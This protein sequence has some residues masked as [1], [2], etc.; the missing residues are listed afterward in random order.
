LN[1]NSNML[2]W[3]NKILIVL[4]VKG[5]NV[6]YVN[7]GRLRIIQLTICNTSSRQI[8]LS[9]GSSCV[10]VL[11]EKEELWFTSKTTDWLACTK[12]NQRTEVAH[13]THTNKK[14]PFFVCL[15]EKSVFIPNS[16][17]EHCI[18]QGVGTG[19]SAHLMMLAAAFLS[20]VRSSGSCITSS[21]KLITFIFSSV[22]E[23]K[24]CT[25]NTQLWKHKCK[26]FARHTE[27]CLL[28]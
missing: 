3:N 8:W 6:K 7:Q 28:L 11:S 16:T 25:H 1:N 4:A 9:P 14:W 24:S 12:V 26:A 18:C 2:C 17:C 22:L 5:I 27:L 15:F 13:K 23:S 21:R 20:W 19:Q 10:N